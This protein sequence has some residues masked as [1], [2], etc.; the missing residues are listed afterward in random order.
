MVAHAEAVD[1]YTAKMIVRIPAEIIARRAKERQVNDKELIQGFIVGIRTR[2]EDNLPTLQHIDREV[3]ISLDQTVEKENEFELTVPHLLPSKSYTLY[4]CCLFAEGRGA[5]NTSEKVE[6]PALKDIDMYL[7]SSIRLK[8]Q[9]YVY[10]NVHEMAKIEGVH[11]VNMNEEMEKEEEAMFSQINP[12]SPS[13][14]T[15]TATDEEEPA[16]PTPELAGLSQST[17]NALSKTMTDEEFSKKTA[18]STPLTTSELKELE[19]YDMILNT[20]K[21]E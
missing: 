17:T 9:K 1:P 13:S 3:F 19:E 8:I 18:R 12:S 20:Q 2:R 4:V 14:S 7:W 10:N 6:T 21:R 15:T 5:T 16:E 11:N